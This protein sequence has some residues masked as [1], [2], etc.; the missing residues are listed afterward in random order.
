MS[1]TAPVSKYVLKPLEEEIELFDR[2]LAHLLKFDVFPTEED[3]QAAATK[4]SAKRERVVRTIRQLTEPLTVD[5]IQA[6]SKKAAAKTKSKIPA[7][8]KAKTA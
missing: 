1:T 8:P 2:K 3:R 6:P 5:A 7:K 4:L